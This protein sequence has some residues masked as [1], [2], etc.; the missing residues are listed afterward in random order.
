MKK[1]AIF[2]SSVFLFLLFVSTNCFAFS[3]DDLYTEDRYEPA[4]GYDYGPSATG[5]SLGT[6]IGTGLKSVIGDMGDATI[7]QIFENS[8]SGTTFQIADLII[9]EYGFKDGE[10]VSGT[11]AVPPPEPPASQ[12][13]LDYL[14]VK[15]SQS[16]SVHLYDPSAL[17]GLWDVG[18]LAD[19]S[20]GAPPA[21]SFVRGYTTNP[22]PEPATM[23]LLG[24]GLVGFVATSRRRFKK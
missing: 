3:F 23:L 14:V 16:F 1:F 6:Y 18:Y 10:P 8:I 21:M 19:N 11:W 12:Q 15:G 17:A 22:I 24:S 4:G 13:Y 5:L 20:S 7:L 2:L 9:E